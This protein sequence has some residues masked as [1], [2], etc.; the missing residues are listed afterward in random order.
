MVKL[1]WAQAA[2]WRAGRHHLD[3]RARA[4]KMLEVA[5]RLCGLHAQV[6][7]CAELQ[8]W[9]RV[10]GFDRGA[11]RQ[12]LW[13]DRTLVKCWAMRGTLH[14]L[15]S[16]DLPLWHGA[17]AVNPRYL[18]RAVWKRAFGITLEA[19][20]RFTKAIGAALDGRVLTRE[21]LMRAAAQITGAPLPKHAMNSWGTVLRPAAFAGRLCF[22]PSE[23]QRV[24]FTRPDSWLG[25]TYRP[26]MEAK[27]A[28]AGVTRRYLAVYGPATADDFAKW[29]GGGGITGARRW[30]EALGD[31][32]EE[33]EVEGTRAW[34][35]AAD[36]RGA[37]QSAPAKVV[38]LL[39]GFDPYVI[40]ASRHAHHLMAD[41]P[42]GRVYRQQGWISAVLLV[43]GRMMGVWRHQ[44]KGSRLEVAVEPF[45]R[46]PAWVR[47]GA[48]EEA[49]RLAKFV[50]GSL[51]LAWTEPR[52]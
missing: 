23:G 2:A 12:A 10:E 4:G 3:R 7:S 19:L 13:D 51:E 8:L 1:T 32:A 24:R 39:P 38:R 42:R 5:S 50:G 37:R 18:R 21:E 34:M 28:A 33:V 14:L 11:I 29:W 26:P 20:D 41:V 9:A 25:P 48:A 15:P 49:E 30:I 45:G 6:L 40:G 43:D 35:L 16:S 22:G 27:A 44:L 17:L 46:V 31:E 36:A 47:R 52:P